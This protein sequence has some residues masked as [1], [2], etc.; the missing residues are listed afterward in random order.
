VPTVVATWNVNSIRARL[1]LLLPWLETVRPDIVC[2][3]ETKVQDDSFPAEAVERAGYR[4]VFRGEKSYNG[5]AILSTE[6]IENVRAGFDDDGP[7]DGARLLIGDT[8]GITMVNAYVPQGRDLDH[9]MFEYK[10]DWYRRLHALIDRRF[11]AEDRLLWV[12]DLNVAP[13][14]IDVWW[15]TEKPDAVHVCHHPRV[16]AALEDVMAWGFEDVFRKHNPVPGQYTYFDYRLKGGV[17]SG[18]GWRIDHIL[19]SR[20]LAECCASSWIDLEPRRGEKPSDHTPLL[21][22]FD[23]P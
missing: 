3:Q 19:A 10:L 8:H 22:S 15:G 20:A 14:T 6:P 5:V 11:G 9:P 7:D 16:T 18:K 4:V 12:G 21:A 1:H 13:A 17:E 2:L 23:I